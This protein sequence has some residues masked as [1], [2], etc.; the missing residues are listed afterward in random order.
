[1]ADNTKKKMKIV[2]DIG[3]PA[4]VNF[5]K[6]AARRLLNDGHDVTSLHKTREITI[7]RKRRI[8]GIQTSVIGLSQGSKIFI[9]SDANLRRFFSYLKY[10]YKKSI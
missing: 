3:H 2:I 4:H 10:L 1:M 5:F 8:K 9:N 6:V 7:N